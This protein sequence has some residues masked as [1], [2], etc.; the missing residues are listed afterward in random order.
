MYWQNSVS[1]CS[2]LKLAK[3]F[4]EPFQIAVKINSVDNKL[5]LPQESSIYLVFHI[6]RLK[7]FQGTPPDQAINPLPPIAT[8]AHPI[9]CP[10]KII[11]YRQVKLRGK[12]ITQVLVEWAGLPKED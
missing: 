5:T 7:P 3:K 4:Y 2:Y 12:S 1:H 6:A 8:E 11:V 10:E 9:I